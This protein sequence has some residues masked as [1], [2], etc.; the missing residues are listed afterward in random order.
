MPGDRAK[1]GYLQIDH[2]DSPGITLADLPG[3]PTLDV[4]IVGRGQNFET[5]TRRCSQCHRII[6]FDMQ[7][8]RFVRKCLKCLDYHCDA[9]VATQPFG[10]CETLDAKF[11]RL[12]HE[13]E[14]LITKGSE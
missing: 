3:R 1:E 11:D 8:T 5:V 4:P 10:H 14:L 2:R 7:R 6:V 12:Q 9:C 13:A